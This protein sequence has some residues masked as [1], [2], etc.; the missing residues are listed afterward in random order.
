MMTYHN[1]RLCKAGEV[2]KE[3][4]GLIDALKYYKLPTMG[5]ET[6]REMRELAIHDRRSHTTGRF[7]R[8]LRADVMAAV[9]CFGRC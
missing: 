5:V 3:V 7:N 9:G 4:P 2:S 1:I 6:K 8:L